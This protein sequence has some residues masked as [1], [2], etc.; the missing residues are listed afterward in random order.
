MNIITII[1]NNNLDLSKSK[2]K[3]LNNSYP[4]T[5]NSSVPQILFLCVPAKAVGLSAISFSAALRKD[6]AAIP[7]A[8][9]ATGSACLLLERRRKYE[10]IHVI[11]VIRGDKGPKDKGRK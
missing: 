7:D 3:Q 6:A 4:N 5:F 11:P 10:G 8:K 1:K 9:E 2:K